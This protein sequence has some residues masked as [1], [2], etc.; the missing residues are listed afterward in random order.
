M[1]HFCA[2]GYLSRLFNLFWVASWRCLFSCCACVSA[3]VG[4]A[5]FCALLASGL[6]YYH[7]YCVG[8]CAGVFAPE[9]WSEVVCSH[10]R[11]MP[12]DDVLATYVFVIET[13]HVPYLGGFLLQFR[14]IRFEDGPV[15]YLSEHE[16][17]ADLGC[18]VV[19]LYMWDAF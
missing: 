19:P 5:L 10:F 12:C 14:C 13:I 11:V 2:S 1:P 4:L 6:S 18:V 8:G 15:P 16:H 3:V 7:E 17:F 9:I